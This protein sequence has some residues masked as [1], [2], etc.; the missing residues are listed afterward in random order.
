MEPHLQL[1]FSCS[2]LSFL[3][4]LT[5]VL[6]CDFLQVK[7]RCRIHHKSEEPE[8]AVAPQFWY[9]SQ[10]EP[11]WEHERLAPYYQVHT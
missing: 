5:S 7:V 9:F 10:T 4:Y 6:R 8:H 1:C 11:V 2:D 3:F